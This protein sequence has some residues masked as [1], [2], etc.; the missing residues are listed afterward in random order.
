[1]SLSWLG[2]FVRTEPPP[3][4]VAAFKSIRENSFMKMVI[5][6]SGKSSVTVDGEVKA[7]INSGLVVLLGFEKGDDSNMIE[8]AAERVATI[9]LFQDP[10]T[11]KMSLSLKD[12]KGEALVISQFTL[13][14]DGKKGLRPSFDGALAPNEARLLYKLFCDALRTHVPVQTGVFGVNMD[15]QIQNLGPVT[16]HLSFP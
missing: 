7:Q 14:W 1:M 2:S 4:L 11:E 15:V 3:I 16:F 6:R 9:R 8:Q 13:A 12:I 5:Q 10:A